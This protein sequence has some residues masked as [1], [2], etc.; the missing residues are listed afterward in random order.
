MQE[1][2]ELARAR[3]MTGEPEG[4]PLETDVR[5]SGKHPHRH[6]LPR[7]PRALN[8]SPKLLE[9]QPRRVG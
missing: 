4:K 6:P 2:G 3:V 9:S 1:A 5:T 7:C 8:E